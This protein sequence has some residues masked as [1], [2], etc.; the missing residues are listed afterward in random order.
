MDSKVKACTACTR[1]CWMV[2][3]EKKNSTD[4]HSVSSFFKIMIGDD[5]SKFLFLPP[6]FAHEVSSLVGQ[7]TILEDSSGEQWE[8][9]LSKVNGSLA[10]Q[11]GWNSF[12]LD[13]GLKVGDF[14][15]F[16]H[17]TESHFVVKIYDKTSCEKLNYPERINHRKR[18]RDDKSSTGKDG[19]FGTVDEHSTDKHGSGTSVKF[20]VAAE[21]VGCLNEVNDE[22][23]TDR[24]GSG[25]SVKSAVAAEKGCLKVNDVVE[26]PISG[27]VP[28]AEYIEEIHCMMDRDP[29]VKQGDYGRSNFDLSVFEM[30]NHT[31]SKRS[32]RES[33]ADERSPHQVDSLLRSQNGAALIDKDK[34]AKVV[35]SG[36]GPSDSFN[37]EKKESI[38]HKDSCIAMT[39]GNPLPSPVVNPKEN[40]ENTSN[41][42]NRGMK[43]CQVA[44]GNIQ[45][46]PSQKHNV[47]NDNYQTANKSV[48][49]TMA[50]SSIST[51]FG[52]KNFQSGKMMK[53]VKE[54]PM[55]IESD[56]CGQGSIQKLSGESFKV[57]NGGLPRR[58]SFGVR[59]D[60]KSLPVV[61]L[62]NVDLVGVSSTDPPNFSSLLATSSESFI[63]LPEYLPFPSTKGRSNVERKV[64]L[65]QDPAQRLW[66]VL[67]H[68]K[69]RLIVITTGWEAFSKANGIQSGDQCLFKIE[70]EF[71]GI[72]S[73]SK[74]ESRKK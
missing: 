37:C 44:K 11:Q 24:H 18:M 61:K 72:Y 39:S 47:N 13:H 15:L 69:L 63:E 55:E 66:P 40:G 38:S 7:R 52:T 48:K 16:F 73:V 25:T 60:D 46:T 32:N 68:G 59:K 65:L 5:F 64:V 9:T 34:V 58:V 21:N 70:N 17:L 71:E 23:S 33:L 4:S 28:K 20:G 19:P 10:F 1:M 51:R 12:A 54:E 62:E 57:T 35:G 53:V 42:S 50:A 27:N 36:A 41:M 49:G 14:V 6:K 3:R 74:L 29:G 43:V 67:Y 45:V 22:N 2:H 31:S 26:L 8:V 30:W 56:P